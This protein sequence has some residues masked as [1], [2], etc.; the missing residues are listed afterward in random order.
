MKSKIIV[1]IEYQCTKMVPLGPS[2]NPNGSVPCWGVD[3][4]T[5]IEG[6]NNSPFFQEW[7]Q[8]MH[9]TSWG[10]QPLAEGTYKYP[11]G[12][13]AVYQLKSQKI[14]HEDLHSSQ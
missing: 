7:L 10:C 9:G 14:P 13:F 4:I 1:E 6:D 8:K 2:M 3:A 11:F 5:K 12:E